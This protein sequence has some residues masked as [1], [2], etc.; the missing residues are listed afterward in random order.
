MLFGF[1][2][3][4]YLKAYLAHHG[5]EEKALR[6]IGHDLS[7]AYAEALALGYSPPNDRL[8]DVIT[9]MNEHHKKFTFRYMKGGVFDVPNLYQ[10]ELVLVDLDREIA[11]VTR[12]RDGYA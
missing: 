6:D 4:L 5:V 12:V 3:E 7:R 11:A 1:V 8:R 2:I 9:L 10:T